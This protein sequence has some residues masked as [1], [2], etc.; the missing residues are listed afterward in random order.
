[1]RRMTAIFLC[2]T[3]LLLV[4]APASAQM[5]EQVPMEEGLVRSTLTGAGAVDMIVGFS[6]DTLFLPVGSFAMQLGLKQM[7][8]DNGD[9][10]MIEFPI[11]HPVRFVQSANVCLTD[12]LE[13]LPWKSI[14]E[15]EGDI[16]VRYDIL[17]ERLGIKAEFNYRRLG[18]NIP[19][20]ARIPAIQRKE[21][22]EK[23]ATLDAREAAGRDVDTTS[24]A[25]GE[26]F[27]S[28]MVNWVMSGMFASERYQSG[29]ATARISGPILY[30]T[31]NI[32]TYTR[33]TPVPGT[34][35]EYGISQG[36]WTLALPEFSPLR[37]ITLGVI[38][39]IGGATD[40]S[41]NLSNARLT[42][43]RHLADREL[44]G[45]TSP[46]WDVELY[47]ANNIV[48]VTRADSLGRYSFTLPVG[49]GRV[50]R[51]VHEVGPHGE[52]I[53]TERRIGLASGSTLPG[54]VQYD[55]LLTKGTEYG[56]A[57]Y[58]ANTFITAGVTDWLNIGA[59]VQG[60]A[61]GFDQLSLDSVDVLPVVNA[62]IGEV[63]AVE[64]QGSPRLKRLSGSLDLMAGTVG[65]M[66][67]E[68]DS[69]S[70]VTSDF[71]LRGGLDLPIGPVSTTFTGTLA[72]T[73]RGLSYTLM[74]RIGIGL[75]RFYMT[76][77][78]S[79]GRTDDRTF[80]RQNPGMENEV[81]ITSG[82]RL[83][84]TPWSALSLGAGGGYDHN[85][86]ELGGWNLSATTRFLGVSLGLQ[87]SAQGNEWREGTL[88][89]QM[90]MNFG[91]AR[92]RTVSRYNNDQLLSS[93]SLEGT[94]SVS[95]A[96]FG[97]EKNGRG[98][99]TIV[100]NPFFDRNLNGVQDAGEE[101]GTPI[102]GRLTSA[103][104]NSSRSTGGRFS[105]ITPYVEW[106]VEIDQLSLADE[107]L[108][109]LRS[110]FSVFSLPTSVHVI[111]V[112]FAKGFDISGNC[113]IELPNGKRRSSAGAL[114]GLRL[115]LVSLNGVASYNGEIFYDGSMLVAGVAPGEYR[116]ELDDRQL[117][118]RAVALK[119]KLGTIVIADSR[120]SL[121]QITFVPAAT[122]KVN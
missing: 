9:T 26:L 112:P 120:S 117:S 35:P 53:V 70:L 41:I 108:S 111:D 73:T 63:A 15:S 30:G 66:T 60:R 10:L 22:R 39:Q 62:W 93:S 110:T 29:T 16:Y 118:E 81:R 19:F 71:A 83:S 37:R 84:Y 33:H 68:L 115:R 17:L 104:G 64:L 34:M 77:T 79:F 105:G 121:P 5:I 13:A 40:F 114:N 96:G 101:V 78:S 99:T 69:I 11:G 50:S 100:L 106:R 36:D 7:M 52:R 21:N 85:T 4:V 3:A 122:S 25:R 59:S 75:G 51:T 42:V 109:P 48:A 103:D 113:E 92:S 82:A 32:N 2:L 1:M 20:D 89:A 55:A 28:A 90:S 102:R 56:A 94:F 95:S 49:Y 116:L 88:Q 6:G 98:G 58:R 72:S 97:I 74:P 47:E 31:A 23:Y 43:P 87:Y 107:D 67:F 38:P 18:L 91:V 27:G 44:S 46:G 14:R 8:S 12:S 65:R 54:E 80:A 45:T 61:A 57:M 24:V 86:G 76:A 119:E